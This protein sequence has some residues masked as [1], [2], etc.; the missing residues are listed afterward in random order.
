[1]N[2]FFGVASI[3]KSP[4]FE[5]MLHGVGNM[6]GTRPEVLQS[7]DG[8]LQ[9][10]YLCDHGSILG[11][12]VTK[13]HFLIYSGLLI[14]SS[15]ANDFPLK[16]D[17]DKTAAYLLARYIERGAEFLDGFEGQFVMALVDKNSGHLD[18]ACDTDGQRRLFHMTAGDD[19]IFGTHLV[20]L[21]TAFESGIEIDRSMEDFLLGYEF[22]PFNRTPYKDVTYLPSG[23]M[24][25]YQ[26]GKEIATRQTAVPA[27]NSGKAIESAEVA[28]EETVA[29]Q[30]YENFMA[31]VE[32]QCPS[33]KR[34]AVLL[35]GFDSALVAAALVRLG[36]EVEAFTFKF[37]DSSYNQQHAETLCHSLGIIHNW[38][39]ITPE[40]IRN[41]L[42]CY[43]HWFNQPVSQAHYPIQIAY[44][45]S[46]IREHG[47]THCF[48]GDGCDELFLGYPTVYRRA[49]LFQN[50]GVIPGSIAHLLRRML[51]S[52]FLERHL[53]HV[54]R[55]ARNVISILARRMPVRGHIAARTF[56]E[57]SLSQLRAE[58]PPFQEHVS[59]QLLVELVKGQENK[60]PLRLAY[61]GKSVVGITRNRTEGATTRTGV[62]ICSPFQEGRLKAY[63]SGL[64]DTMLRPEEKTKAS[65]TGKYILMK[66]AEDSGLLSAEVIYQ[67]KASP[68]TAPVDHWY[69]NPLRQFLLG[70]LEGLPFE[71]NSR[72]INDLPRPKLAE[73]L[74]RKHFTLGRYTGHAISLLTTYASFTRHGPKGNKS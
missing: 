27:I 1:M 26:D 47:F 4:R 65:A 33:S 14:S 3:R 17:P 21:A 8:R 38:V 24:R 63:V 23:E 61:H 44:A 68:V 12:A 67:P 13:H 31:A 11:K 48:T 34:V 73:I 7:D 60:T 19:L 40:V 32:A 35:G 36:K 59:E 53:G 22:L 41:G 62:I 70:L 15:L 64:P 56:D 10:G 74:Y 20:T 42:E 58:S 51:S 43:A 45:L 54:V 69:T 50:T 25:E 57:Y 16:D 30:L 9:L 28:T 2:L 6:Y 29:K 66:M 72:Y 5:K 55:Q 49:R 37:D 18:L 52:R 39:H 46:I 71:F